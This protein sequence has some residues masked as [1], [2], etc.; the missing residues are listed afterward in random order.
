[1]QT[2]KNGGLRL[3]KNMMILSGLGLSPASAPFLITRAERK[4]DRKDRR[5]VRGS[6]KII[7]QVLTP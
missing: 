5:T 6:F 1:V 4:V 3:K 7:A 2:D